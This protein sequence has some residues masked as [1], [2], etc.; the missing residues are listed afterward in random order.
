MELSGR[1]ALVTGGGRRLGAA[2]AAALAARGMRVAIHYHASAEG[3]TELRERIRAAGG[4]AECFAAD[5][6]DPEAARALA[7]RVVRALGGLDVLVNS[8]AIM[9]HR[10][11]EETTPADWD[12]SLD[13]NLRAPFFVAQGAAAA[14]RA[15]RGKIVNLADLSGLEPWPGYAAHSV[16]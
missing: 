10:P 14:L 2:F 7:G 1:V 13:L 9:L 4:T 15:A 3:A 6:T 5:L 12:A 16:S 8:A 11:F